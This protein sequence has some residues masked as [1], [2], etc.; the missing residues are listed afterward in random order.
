MIKRIIAAS[1]LLVVSAGLALAED[2]PLGNPQDKLSYNLGVL[3]GQNLKNNYPELNYELLFEALKAQ[4]GGGETLVGVEE[5]NAWMQTYSQ[6]QT[7]EKAAAARAAGLEY[8]QDNAL[9]KEVEVTESGLQYEVITAVDGAKPAATDTVVVHYHGMLV[10]GTVFDSSVDR[11]QPATFP[12]NRVIPGWTEGVQLM[13]V[14]SKY[15]FVIPS[16]LAYGEQ[17][18]RPTIGPGETLIFEV[19]LLEIQPAGS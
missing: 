18:A 5:A 8:L 10:D 15:R 2:D 14:G 9:R 7:Q 1:V 16:E 12:L 19:E 3:I 4:H 11:G 6:Q 17:G 13:S